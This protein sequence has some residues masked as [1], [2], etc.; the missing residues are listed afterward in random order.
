MSQNNY[1]AFVYGKAVLMRMS[2]LV[3]F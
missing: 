2:G 3:L 1:G